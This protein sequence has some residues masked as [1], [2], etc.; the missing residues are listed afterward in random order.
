M[1]IMIETDRLILRTWRES[2]LQQMLTINQD[3]KVMEY[4]P[5]LQDLEATT[6]FITKVNNH[7][8]KP[9]YSLYATTRKDTSEFIGFIGLLIAN[10]EAHFTP[11]TEIGWRLSSKHWD[12]GFA[13]EGAQ[14]VLNHAFRELKIPE[15]V[16]FTAEGNAQSIK[17]MQKIGLRHHANDD[18]DHPKLEDT[19]PLKR[20]VLYRLSKEEYLQGET[21]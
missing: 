14:A 9:G 16:S 3:P 2:D 4:F 12:K 7:F 13:T 11:A 1:K 19:S 21:Q 10:F 15:I 5:G 20:H 8:D 6:N 18:F 17:V